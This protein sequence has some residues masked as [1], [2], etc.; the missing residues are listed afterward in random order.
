MSNVLKLQVFHG[1]RVK[2]E[3]LDDGELKQRCIE[4]GYTGDIE[5]TIKD[6]YL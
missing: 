1:Y 2:V 3:S 5:T 4:E 6:T